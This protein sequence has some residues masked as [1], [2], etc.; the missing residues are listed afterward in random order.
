[1][2]ATVNR[3]YEDG[4]GVVI[5]N[6][7]QIVWDYETNTPISF[8]SWKAKDKKSGTLDPVKNIIPHNESPEEHVEYVFEHVLRDTI[9]KDTE[10]DVIACG[11]AAYS[12]VKYLNGHCK[13]SFQL[14][15]EKEEM[16]LI[17]RVG[18]YWSKHMFAMALAE[19]SHA[20]NNITSEEF[21]GFLVGVCYPFVSPTDCW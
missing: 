2:I 8:L 12:I 3:A 19:S 14:C 4:Y 9:H 6:P 11:F 18:D 16:I 20:I 15:K 5:L 21:R 13:C 7:A 10:I 1:M 17:R